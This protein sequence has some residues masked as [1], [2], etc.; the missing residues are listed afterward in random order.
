[1][2]ATGGASSGDGNGGNGT[3]GDADS[4]GGGV[5]VVDCDEIASKTPVSLTYDD[6][7]PTHV[8]HVGPALAAR[9][10]LATFFVT[11]VRSNPAPWTALRSE[12]H[13]MGVHTFNHP[14]PA[15]N[16]WV[17][18]GKA[19][20]D[21]DLDRMATELDQG[22]AMLESLGQEAPFTF[23]YPCGVTWVGE[24]QET[25]VPLIE[26][27]FLAARGVSS[28]IAGRSPDF[29]NVP[30]YF[31][32]T[33]GADLIARAEAALVAKDWLVY[34]FHG[35]GGDWEIVPAEA[36]DELLDYLNDHSDDFVVAPFGQVAACL[37]TP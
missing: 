33:T 27:R 24:A 35:V 1:M 22:L 14:C 25:Y 10:M 3:G 4:M 11:D 16:S 30:A 26:E 9:G 5:G 36:H 19:N 2:S 23:A 21:Y 28:S 13:E 8:S 29:F 31:L 34:G 18:A 7:A 15:S 6:A 20:E 32:K 17:E 37:L 12:G